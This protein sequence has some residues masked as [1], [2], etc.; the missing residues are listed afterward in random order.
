MLYS[1]TPKTCAGDADITTQVWEAAGLLV[2]NCEYDMFDACW[3]AC[4]R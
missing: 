1:W 2:Q 4:G 3:I